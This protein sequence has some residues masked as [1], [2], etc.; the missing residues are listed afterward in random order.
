M[1]RMYC[2]KVV[3]LSCFA[4]VIAVAS[5]Q[6]FDHASYPPGD[7]DKVLEMPKPKTGVD[8]ISLQKFRLKVTLESYERKCHVADMIKLSASM[9]RDMYPPEFTASLSKSKCVQVKSPKGVI[10]SL[11]I[12]DKVAEF[13][14]KEVPLGSEILAYCVLVCMLPDGPGMVIADFQVPAAKGANRASAQSDCYH[15]YSLW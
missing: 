5:A 11:A 4:A 8:V 15:Y 6:A 7:L 9:L 13:L 14:P 10:V 1:N 2:L 3:A 12:Q